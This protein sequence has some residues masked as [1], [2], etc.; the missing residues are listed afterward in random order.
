MYLVNVG[1]AMSQNFDLPSYENI[2]AEEMASKIGL[3]VKHI[4]I[5]VGSFTTE[6]K[7]LIE[8]LEAAIA[9]NDYAGISSVAHSIKGS[10]GNLKFE[11]IYELS[12]E[13]ELTAKEASADYPYAQA[14]ESLKRAIYSISL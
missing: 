9:A 14:C 8:E 2:S 3:N 12:K 7:K 13:V 6:S 5:L 4:P 10:S 1:E 11:E